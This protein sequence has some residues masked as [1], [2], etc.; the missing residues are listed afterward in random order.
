MKRNKVFF[1][2]SMSLDG[3]IAPEG[4][5][6][7]H[8]DDPTYK[9]W[10]DK[11]LQLQHW[12]F[13]QKSFKEKLKLGEGGETGADNRLYEEIFGR[14][15][16]TILGKNMF[17]GG[18]KYWPEE[19]PF[20][21][22]VFVLT[23]EVREPWV[24]PGGTTFYFENDG[25][26]GALEKAKE[27]AGNRDIR[28]GGGADVI[29]QYLDAGLVDEFIIHLSPVFFGGGIP[30]FK[31][32]NENIALSLRDTLPSKYVTHITYEVKPNHLVPIKP[33]GEFL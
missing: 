27:V 4:M 7:A 32:V 3:Y 26:M 22:P 13:Q 33:G 19:A 12:I 5:D 14:T 10:L 2:V 25:I 11:W 20:H 17:A 1:A 18:E 29:Q 30:L 15:G 6:L 24:R 8:A 31:D 9:N 21:T 28:I 16:V 23:H